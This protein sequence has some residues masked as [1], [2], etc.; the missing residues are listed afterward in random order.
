MT[1]FIYSIV[2]IGAA[3]LIGLF[4]FAFPEKGSDFPGSLMD[5]LR[6]LILCCTAPLIALVMVPMGIYSVVLGI[7]E[8]REPEAR[9]KTLVVV[10]IFLGMLDIVAGSGFLFYLF[11]IFSN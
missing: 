9:G 8:I 4:V 5:V 3:G 7:A 10:A 11:M 2:P 1:P 6:P